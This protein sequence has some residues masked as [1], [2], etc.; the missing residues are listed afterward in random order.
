MSSN[1][2]ECLAEIMLECPPAWD[3]LV[4]HLPG[5]SDNCHIILAK[6]GTCC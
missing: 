3:P 6:S 5:C 2:N 1:L 4:V